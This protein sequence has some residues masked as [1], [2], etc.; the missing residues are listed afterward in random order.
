MTAP[1]PLSLAANVADGPD[2]YRF[3][4]AD[5]V[6]SADDFRTP[7]LLMLRAIH[8]D[9]P[10]DH[11][12]VQANYGVVGVGLAASVDSVLMAETSARRARLCRRNAA[13]NSADARTAIVA[14]LRR[15]PGR[16]DTASYAPES[17]TPIDVGRQRIAHALA[18]LRP[19][20]RLYVAAARETGRSR[21]ERCLSELAGDCRT[22]AEAD[23]YSVLVV[24]R[25]DRV[26]PDTFV[27]PTRFTASVDGVDLS[28][29]TVSGMFAARNLD[30]GTRLLAESVTVED[31]E[32][33]LDLCCGAG[34][35]GVYAGRAADCDVTLSD[36][37][38][39]ATRAAACSLK[40]SGV[41]G[42]VVTADGTAGVAGERFDRVLC[43]PPTHAANGVLDSLFAGA[44]NVL[45]PDGELHLVH[46]RV[47]DLQP[48]LR[49]FGTVET[50][51]SGDEHVVIAAEP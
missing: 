39:V 7:E 1:Q 12:A 49:G 30:D 28:L 35:L 36:D 8:G 3:H 19:G 37:C 48:H 42:R 27:T 25:P 21:Y 24:E 34:P 17:H 47:L 26:D 20:G 14:D 38:R 41:E 33:V 18:M 46:H 51:A 13:A 15:L 31:N 10:G 11:L 45:K 9:D 32:R 43:N 23:G 16:Y 22:V 2:V 29:V 50:C 5:G 44:R 40:R 4:T 6:A